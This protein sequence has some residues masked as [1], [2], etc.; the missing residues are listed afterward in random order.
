VNIDKYAKTTPNMRALISSGAKR[1]KRRVLKDH[2]Q[3]LNI[4]RKDKSK[5]SARV[6]FKRAAWQNDFLASLLA[7]I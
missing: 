4:V 2:N 3:V 6:K 7:Q 5:G 1:A